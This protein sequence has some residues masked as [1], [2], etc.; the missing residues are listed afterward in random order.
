MANDRIIVNLKCLKCGGAPFVS[1]D[2]PTDDSVVKCK[3]CG[4]VFGTYGQVKAQATEH[5]RSKLADL[6]KPGLD[7]IKD[8]FKR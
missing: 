5:A 7:A 8:M 1:E 3:S 4:Q 6:L 2:H